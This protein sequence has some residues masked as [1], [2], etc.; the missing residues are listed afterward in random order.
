MFNLF[1]RNNPETPT[2][3]RRLCEFGD[4]MRMLKA[5][6]KFLKEELEKFKI[7]A[8]ES[9]KKY[10]DKLVRLTKEE[11]SSKEEEKSIN[12]GELYL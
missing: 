9:R 3:Q 10:T 12:T 6:L 2:I 4:D 11:E 5:E 1:K 8:L 7:I